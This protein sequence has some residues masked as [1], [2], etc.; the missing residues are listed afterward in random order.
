MINFDSISC[1][2]PRFFVI[3]GYPTGEEKGTYLALEISGMDVYVCQVKLKGERG[4]LS[5]NQ[6]QY[7]IPDELAIGEDVSVLLDYLTDCVADFLSRVASQDLFVY[8]M[9]LRYVTVC[10]S[11]FVPTLISKP[12]FVCLYPEKTALAFLCN[13]LV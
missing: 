13:S 4:T 12:E 7:R 6:Y 11:T 2:R 10:N 5:I 1:D 9:G 3:A 8:S